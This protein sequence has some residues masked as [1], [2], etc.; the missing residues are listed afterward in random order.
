MLPLTLVEQ[1]GARREVKLEGRCLPIGGL[2]LGGSQR[3]ESVW[4]QGAPEASVQ[5]IG[6][7]ESPT[8]ISGVWVTKYFAS[9]AIATVNGLRVSDAEEL[10]T[11]F[12]LIRVQ[13]QLLRFS[14]GAIV[15]FGH[16]EKF[17]FEYSRT[18]D[19]ISWTMELK[20]S[21]RGAS[22]LPPVQALQGGVLDA[23]SALDRLV[24]TVEAKLQEARDFNLVS[25]LRLDVIRSKLDT[26]VGLASSI[27]SIVSSLTNQIATAIGV[28][29]SAIGQLSQAIATTREM[30]EETQAVP[31]AALV[32]TAQ[33]GR[34]LAGQTVAA[35][36]WMQTVASSGGTFVAQASDLKRSLEEQQINP[37]LA[38]VTARGVDSLRTLS[39]R[40]FD[41][42]DHWR[43]IM[44]FNGLMSEELRTGQVVYIPRLQGNT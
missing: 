17:D 28:V 35:A 9:E 27:R 25:A 23:S 4:Y 26:L 37:I 18:A 8:T 1:A 24:S 19:E 42:E 20:W 2:K 16:L 41:T 29:N 6:P 15:R 11:I 44:L 22:L 13:G 31:Y 34:A 7:E 5:V 36:A 32:Q 43:E 14:W 40:F 39:L 38:T 33:N 30:I 12:D 21:S 3:L 10:A